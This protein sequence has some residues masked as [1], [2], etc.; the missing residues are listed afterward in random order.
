MTA[1]NK[2]TL[3]PK[4]EANLKKIRLREAFLDLGI[5]NVLTVW[6]TKL[7]NGSLPHLEIREKLLK[8]LKE[9]R[10]KMKFPKLLT[11]FL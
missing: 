11:L 5:L 7:P 9:V 2:L 8:I 1:I 6:L 3:L 10:Q 4:V